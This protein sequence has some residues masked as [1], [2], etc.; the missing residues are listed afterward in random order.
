M[1]VE[2]A[3]LDHQRALAAPLHPAAQDEE[4]YDPAGLHAEQPELHHRRAALDEDVERN[5]DDR[6]EWGG[7][8]QPNRHRMREEPDGEVQAAQYPRGQRPRGW[9]PAD[10]EQPVRGGVHEV[11]AGET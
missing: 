5:L 2:L 9:G 4:R 10:V 1:S 8:D 6:R 3:T 7:D 11:A